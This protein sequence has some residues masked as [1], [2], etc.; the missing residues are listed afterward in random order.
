MLGL[1]F[2]LLC[3]FV[4]I[5]SHA[6]NWRLS[7]EFIIVGPGTSK[8]GL[9]S[10]QS[11]RPFHKTF[12]KDFSSRFI[13]FICK[14][15]EKYRKLSAWD[16]NN[17]TLLLEFELT[18]IIIINSTGFNP[19]WEETITFTLTFPNLA[20]FRFV[21]WD[22]DPVGR[23]FIGQVTMPFPSIMEGMNFKKLSCCNTGE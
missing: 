22:E 18:A 15:H 8:M 23:D 20:I 5:S 13:N 16:N 9:F 6:N 4:F 2:A 17:Y 10:Q 21:V 1:L 11:F 7:N 3:L 19:V 14:R 12:F